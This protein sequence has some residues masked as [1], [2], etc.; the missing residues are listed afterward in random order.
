MYVTSDGNY[1]ISGDIYLITKE[2]LVN[3][4]EARR[5]YQRKVMMQNLDEEELIIFEPE[6]IAH[7]IYVF[8]DVDCGY[9]R[10]FHNQIDA[11]LSLGIKVHYL[12]YPRAGIGSD[13]YNKIASAWCN[14]DP[15][16]SLT[17]LK[18]GR[19]ID[20]LLCED[21]PVESHFELG[22]AMGVQG[23]PSIVTE[24]GKMIPGYLPPQDLLNILTTSS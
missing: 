2:G 24:E 14:T 10:Q 17:L 13:S 6:K 11:Y 5:D 19:E 9:C 8:T 23:T 22:R 3:K 21:N 20:R 7:S 12:A 18:Q 15:N 1:L 4:S 16:N